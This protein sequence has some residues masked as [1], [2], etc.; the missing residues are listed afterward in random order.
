[1]KNPAARE[2]LFWAIGIALVTF[3]AYLP[4]LHGTFLWDDSVMVQDNLMLRSAQGLRDFWATTKAVDPLPVTMTALW[5]QWQCWGSHTFG[6]HVAGVC[7]HIIAALL[8]WRALVI[9][10]G[11]PRPAWIAAAV[12]AL[13]PVAVASVAWISEQKN[14]LS[15]VF[16]LLSIIFFLREAKGS[17]I[18]YSL[19]LVFFALAL[20]GKGSVVMLPV[21]L[22]FAV[23]WQNGKLTRRDFWRTLPFFILC[24]LD[25]LYTIWIQNHKAIGGGVVQNLRGS[26]RLAAAGQAVLFYAWKALMPFDL[27][28][29]YPARKISWISIIILTT[30]LAAGWAWRKT[31][32][33]HFLFGFGCF[34]A[35]LFPVMGF[36]N[37]YFLSYSRVADHWQYLALPP[38]IALVIFACARLPK[39]LAVCLTV[40]A[41]AGLFAAT[42]TRA[43][44][45]T[46]EK[47]LWSDTV[48]KNPEAWMAWNNLGNALGAE[49]DNDGSI[50]AYEK[51]LAINP[52]FPDAESN[53][54]NALV[55]KGELGRALIHLQKAVEEEPAMAKFHFNYGAGLGASGKIEEAIAEYQEALKLRPRMAD[56]RNNLANIYYQQKKYSE[57]LQEAQTAMQLNPDLSEPYLNAAK[58]LAALN[59]TNAA[60]QNFGHFLRLRPNNAGAQYD[61]GIMLAM[62]GDLAGALPH[63]QAVVRLKPGDASG[64]GSLGNTFAGLKRLDE[65][66]AEFRIALQFAP[67][68]AQNENNL[69]TALLEKG[70]IDESIEHYAASVRLNPKDVSTRLNYG[71]ALLQRGR[72]DE[73]IAQYREAARLRPGDPAIRQRL[74]A[75]RP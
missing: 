70:S 43:A 2:N 14:T 4:A 68:D 54:G 28:V 62:R 53:L 40:A 71:Y 56:V 69:A 9:L 61:Y 49:N 48:K 73:A 15:I 44:V 72:R 47:S 27:C 60:A 17:P 75:L 3:L 20:L 29:I 46:N 55:G 10:T 39:I 12:F 33:R 38:L 18:R 65:A 63:F 74:D 16:Y 36:F 1:M 19:S 64:H 37:M 23:W 13:H 45:Y 8:L 30:A 21:I 41:F 59:D 58:A 50:A 5:L 22:L 7:L 32:G 35:T 52:T 42:W 31:W 6:Y 57:A 11:K 26:D 24:G 67:N 51:A 66:I 25:S 34:V